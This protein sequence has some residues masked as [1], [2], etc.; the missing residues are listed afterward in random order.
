[1]SGF[2]DSIV[3]SGQVTSKSG[4]NLT[5]YDAEPEVT[6]SFNVGGKQVISHINYANSGVNLNI[7]TGTYNYVAI[8]VV[9]NTHASSAITVRYV[10][11]TTTSISSG[12]SKVFLSNGDGGYYVL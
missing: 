12:S 2:Y 7:T 9:V 3:S 6:N 1:M 10:D 11:A 8:L 4:F 5:N